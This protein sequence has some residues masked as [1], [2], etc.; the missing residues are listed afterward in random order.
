MTDQI[1]EHDLALPAAE[2]YAQAVTIAAAAQAKIDALT[3]QVR[4]HAWYRS[5]AEMQAD[6][7]REQIDLGGHRLI[8]STEA[9][10]EQDVRTLLSLFGG[11]VWTRATD[12]G[13]RVNPVDWVRADHGGNPGRYQWPIED[14]GPFIVL[15]DADWGI[16][17]LVAEAKRREDAERDARAVIRNRPGYRSDDDGVW[18]EPVLADAVARVVAALDAKCN[19]ADRKRYAV[20]HERDQ[21]QRQVELLTAQVAEQQEP[22]VVDWGAL[23]PDQRSSYAHAHD[24]AGVCRKN[25]HGAPCVATEAGEQA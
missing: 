7:L 10:P 1:P 20:E 11:N 23:T 12:G 25:R 4:D 14:Q 3:E 6:A 18:S 8:L 15:P 5:Q 17:R 22:V 2:R 16:N 19:D 13:G 24:L 21:L 9:E